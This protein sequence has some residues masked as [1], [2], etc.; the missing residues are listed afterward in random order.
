MSSPA[1]GCESN[2]CRRASAGGQ[3]E[4]PSEVNN[5][6]STG[7]RPSVV[8]GDSAA[9]AGTLAASERTAIVEAS[10]ILMASKYIINLGHWMRNQS[11]SYRNT[12]SS[13]EGVCNFRLSY[14]SK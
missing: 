6:T 13:L 4:H 8:D 7:T 11:T 5:S 1:M 12:G 2:F 9:D 10:R 14:E 3:L